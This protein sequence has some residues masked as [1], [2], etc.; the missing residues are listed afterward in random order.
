VAFTP[1]TKGH[2]DGIVVFFHNAATR[3][4]TVR[5]SGECIL[6][7][8][9]FVAS[10]KAVSF[11]VVE[12]GQTKTDS[13]N[14]KNAGV[15][16]LH[17]AAVSS[18]DPVFTVTPQTAS[19]AAGDSAWFAIAFGPTDAST[20]SALVIFA[21]NTEA[22]KDTIS[23][24]GGA[25]TLMTI[26]GAR[27]LPVGSSV[28]I[29]GIVTRAFGPYTR[30]Q[31]STAAITIY[32]GSGQFKTEVDSGW[33][34]KGDL[35]RVSGLTSDF[36]AL[37][38]IAGADLSWYQN[39]SRGHPLP[40]A[41][42]ISLAEVNTNGESYESQLIEIR[43][44]TI[45][46]YQSGADSLTFT[47]QKNY[48]LID[49]TFTDGLA[50]YAPSLRIGRATEGF[51]AEKMIPS[52]RFEFLGV[53]GQFGPSDPATGY[54]LMPVDSLDM[55]FYTVGVAEN[56]MIPTQ[57]ALD[58]NYPNPFNPTTTIQYALPHQSHVTLVIYSLLG[59]EVRTLVN[60]VQGSS[61][62]RITWDGLN[63]QGARVTS[64]IYFYRIVAEPVEKGN[65]TF[66]EVKKM[67]M[68]K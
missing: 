15:D 56:H 63:D 35:I 31:D 26:A 11:G 55:F 29:Q 54:Q 66:T 7:V 24:T 37:R 39:V 58:N 4:D 67:I 33:I 10:P 9:T 20:K 40:A 60:D 23:V 25:Y 41:K 8:P 36:Y 43:N 50:A 51:W 2:E 57:F 30:I 22:G 46:G 19:I 14:V 28:T 5:V 44:L 48:Y 34:A 32:Q 1:T 61:Y 12:V 49:S 65:Q 38:E 68:L 21:D 53:L 17:V 16:V 42:L 62:Y 64:G 27:A 45:V 3:Q 6:K 13:V 18:T 52:K 59:Q 47:A